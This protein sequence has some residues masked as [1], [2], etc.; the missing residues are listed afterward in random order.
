MYKGSTLYREETDLSFYAAVL[1][2]ITVVMS[3]LVGA[4]SQ[5][6]IN[7]IV[8]AVPAVVALVYYGPTILKNNSTKDQTVKVTRTNEQAIKAT[9]NNYSIAATDRMN[10]IQFER[11]CAN[12][13]KMNGFTNVRLTPNTGDYGADIIAMKEDK[14]YAIQ[15]KRY[16][17][18]V[19]NRAV[20]E[21][22]TAKAYYRADV[23]VVMT[24]S[25]FSNAAMEQAKRAGV[26]LWSRHKL[27][28]LI[29]IAN[30][31]QPS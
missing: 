29:Q 12:L 28:K 6:Y 18:P 13:L 26:L 9:H 21:V 8:V 2:L 15:C 14:K 31:N 19:G 4:L 3:V 30:S 27:I 24:N 5:S 20:Q 17:N 1:I 23:A 11:Y 16:T 25:T 7:G 22:F 10:G